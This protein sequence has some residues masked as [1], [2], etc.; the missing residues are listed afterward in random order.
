MMFLESFL[1]KMAMTPEQESVLHFVKQRKN[2]F[3]TS[4]AG[5]GKS[6][7]IER[8]VYWAKTEKI[9]FGVTAMTGT[10]AI[11]INGRTL[12]SFL[13]IGLGKDKAEDLAS[14]CNKYVKQKLMKL[15]LLI[16]DEVSML[17]IELFEKISTYLGLIRK[18]PDIPFG[19]IQLLFSGDMFQL[20]PVKGDYCFQSKLW[21]QCQFQIVQFTKNMRQQKDTSFQTLLQSLRI[22]HCSTTELQQLKSLSNTEFTNGITPTRLY[23]LNIDVDNINQIELQELIKTT[24]P[25]LKTY[26]I[27]FRNKISQAKTLIKSMNV[28]ESIQLCSNAQ[29]VLTRNLQIE[30][31]LVNGSRGVVLEVTDSAVLVK[32]QNGVI[33]PITYY[34]HEDENEILFSYIPLRLAYAL[35]IHKCQGMTLDAIEIDLGK[36][37]F[38]WGQ[39]YTAL[40]RA[41]DMASIRIIDIHQ[42]SFR[43]HP[44]VLDFYKNQS[45]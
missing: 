10:A 26:S 23:S 1:T 15:R 6:Y 35:S 43:T 16:V 30:S 32:F 36:S 38:C 37:I 25:I 40:S 24:H 31:G 39:A 17:D 14:V 9:S 28:P 12:H 34:D 33:Y 11:L 20:P 8:I 19:G 4:P 3:M 44:F 13:G 5:Y 2:V 22:G 7:V 29:V 42:K 27:R 45:M 18:K 41:K 21:E